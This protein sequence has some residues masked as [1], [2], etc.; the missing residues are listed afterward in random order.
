MNV[1]NDVKKIFSFNLE[2]S[3]I[4]ALDYLLV[5]PLRR[6]ELVDMFL[7]YLVIDNPDTAQSFIRERKREIEKMVAGI[8]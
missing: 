3:T 1:N 4:Q 2:E 8:E 6:S 7:R 5:E